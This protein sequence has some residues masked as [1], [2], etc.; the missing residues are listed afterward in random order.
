M[1]QPVWQAPQSGEPKFRAA[2]PVVA[3]KFKEELIPAPDRFL[4]YSPRLKRDILRDPQRGVYVIELTVPVSLSNLQSFLN[5]GRNEE[6]LPEADDL[7]GFVAICEDL[8]ADFLV[9][10]ILN[11]FSRSHSHFPG[12]VLDL[13]SQLYT[14]DVK[15]PALESYIAIHLDDYLSEAGEDRFFQLPLSVLA[16]ICARANSGALPDSRFT[17]LVNCLLQFGP[18]ASTFFIGAR[19]SD[20]QLFILHSKSFIAT[21][22]EGITATSAT[23]SPLRSELSTVRRD[24]SGLVSKAEMSSR[25]LAKLSDFDRFEQELLPIAATLATLEANITKMS[26]EFEGIKNRSLAISDADIRRQLDRFRVRQATLKHRVFPTHPYDRARLLHGIVRALCLTP[27]ALEIYGPPPVLPDARYEAKNLFELDG[28]A[29][30]YS[31]GVLDAYV[32]YHFVE[33]SVIVT[34]YALRSN[35]FLNVHN[36]MKWRIEVSDNGEDWAVVD[37]QENEK[38]CAKNVTVGFVV[39][40]PAVGKWIRLVQTG[41][42]S[43][44]HDNLLVSAFELFGSVLDEK[45]QIAII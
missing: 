24:I 5:Y 39:K 3:V 40:A 19:L 22:T 35:A 15:T 18:L 30:F 42:N 1:R 43:S 41:K 12:V 20:D 8:E 36:L 26:D 2:Q 11:A 44:G 33:K 29:C 34:H 21:L 31:V 23:L 17:F 4:L 28:D 27:N 25:N 9:F 10:T 13:F 6:L 45:M 7:A 38:M 16:R 37:E 32:A 14:K